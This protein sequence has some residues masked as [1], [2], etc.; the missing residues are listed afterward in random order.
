VSNA[1]I[2]DQL[3]GQVLRGRTP[4]ILASKELYTTGYWYVR[5]CQAVVNA[6]ESAP[7][8]ANERTG[9]LSRPFAELPP[10]LRRR[11][12]M[13]VLQLPADIGLISLRDLAPTIAQLRRHHQLNILGIEALAAASQLGAQVFLSA[14]SPQLE[15]SLRAERISVRTIRPK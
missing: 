9:V 8:S 15:V 3:L 2:D 1:L 5:L 13:A 4:R 14:S 7:D 6:N 11:A 12:V 10:E